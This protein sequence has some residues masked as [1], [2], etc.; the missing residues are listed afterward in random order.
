METLTEI[1]GALADQV[2]VRE[3]DLASPYSFVQI[4]EV[5][6]AYGEHDAA[7]AWAERGMAAFPDNPDTRLRAF[8]IKEYRRRGR[9]G[10]ALAHS[11]AAFV[12]WPTLE[13]YCE[14]A[15]DAQALGEWTER[16]AAAIELLQNADRGR[17][18]AA[19]DRWRRRDNTELV[20]VFLWEQDLESAW[21]AAREGGCTDTLWLE[22]ADR[23]R[24]EHPEDALKVYRGHVEHTIAGK[25]KRSYAEAIRL[26]KQMIDPLFVECGRAA[27]FDTYLAE[28]RATH[29]QK[30]N[31]MK[32]M[33]KLE[34]TRAA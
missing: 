28:V 10:G 16:R 9:S 3:R 24:A 1:S 15:I 19:A 29:R 30:R 2:A 14:L 13:T 17:R 32:L 25:D 33:D 6:R 23:R 31:L 5:C 22:L 26:M 4:A 34:A 7:L 27:D 12:A 8:L 18:G 20:R 11:W 21:R